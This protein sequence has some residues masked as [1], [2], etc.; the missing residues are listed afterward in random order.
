MDQVEQG[1]VTSDP[2]GAPE[3][4][5]GSPRERSQR[6][7]GGRGTPSLEDPQA[8][9]GVRGYSWPGA[10]S[11]HFAIRSSLLSGP[12]GIFTGNGGSRTDLIFTG[13]FPLAV[14]LPVF[15]ALPESC[16]AGLWGSSFLQ[17]ALAIVE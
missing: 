7:R 17:A 6:G 12:L 15:S 14:L 11:Q 13:W 4:G 16:E 8:F 2:D 1:G 9:C 3:E 10:K 5:L